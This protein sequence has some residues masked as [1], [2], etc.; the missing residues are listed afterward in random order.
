MLVITYQYNALVLYRIVE[1]KKK[2]LKQLYN[3]YFTNRVQMFQ[4]VIVP[5]RQAT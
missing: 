2:P 4:C 3:V 1:L 5:A